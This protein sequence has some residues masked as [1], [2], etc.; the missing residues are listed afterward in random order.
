M[1]AP[2]APPRMTALDGGV[3]DGITWAI[4]RAPLYGA[5]NGYARIPEGHPWQG[6]GYDDDPLTDVHAHGGLTF[7][8]DGWIG[9][10]TLHAGDLWPGEGQPHFCWDGHCDCKVWTPALVAAEARALARQVAGA[11]R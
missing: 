5:I 4:V 3:E 7:A 11:A 6:L 2:I 10:D 1:T 8:R 9:F